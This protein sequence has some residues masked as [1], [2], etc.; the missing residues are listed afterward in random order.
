MNRRIEILTEEPSMEIFLKGLLPRILPTEYALGVN[1]FVYP[2]EGKNDLQKRLP[3][4]VRAYANYPEEILLIVIQD[5]DSTDCVKLKGKL[6]NLILEVNPNMDYLIRIAC[7]ELENW[8][9]GDLISIQSIYPESRASRLA[10]KAKFRDVDHLIG[11]YEMKKFSRKFGKTSCARQM[12]PI[13]S[14]ESN[15][16]PSFKHFI[17]GLS[18]FLK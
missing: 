14:I 17:T 18:R 7:R 15:T 10:Q 6:E 13:I 4:R 2:H 11:S 5:Q 9:L 3:R 8:Y 16:S 12:A 1:C